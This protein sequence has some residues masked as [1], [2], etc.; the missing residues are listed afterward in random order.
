MRRRPTT[1]ISSTTEPRG[2][3]RAPTSQLGL[4]L[5]RRR[6]SDLRSD[7]PRAAARRSPAPRRAVAPSACSD[8]SGLVTTVDSSSSR[9]T[10]RA[11]PT[12][13]R[14]I[15]PAQRC[16]GSARAARPRVASVPGSRGP[17][18]VD[19]QP[20]VWRTWTTYGSPVR[21]ARTPARRQPASR[22]PLGPEAIWATGRSATSAARRWR[23]TEPFADGQASAHAR[24]GAATASLP[25][26][27][28][29]GRCGSCAE[30]VAYYAVGLGVRPSG[31]RR[32][33]QPDEL[34]AV[35]RRGARPP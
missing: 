29:Q 22:V 35:R 28:R 12:S 30:D 24:S 3:G 16:V 4:D 18:I 7:G 26:A 31:R 32:A 20:S 2:P 23:P 10:T 1:P 34:V 6:R 9:P 11:L 13:S 15:A 5:S 25:P 21:G 17:D 27:R 14:R 33:G 8:G 19:A